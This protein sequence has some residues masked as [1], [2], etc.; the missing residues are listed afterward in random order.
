MDRLAPAQGRCRPD[1]APPPQAWI[2][3]RRV[4]FVGRMDRRR[5]NDAGVEVD[6]VL[7]L[8]AQTRR[9]VLLLAIFASGSVGL[10]QSSFESFLPLRFRSSRTRSSIDGVATPLSWAMRVSI[11]P[12][13]SR[14]SHAAR[15]FAARRW[16]PWSSPLALHQSAL[17]DQPQNPAEDFLMDLVRQATSR[18]RQPGM[19]GNLVTARKAQKLTKRQGIRTAPRDAPLAVDKLVQLAPYAVKEIDWLDRHIKV[20]VTR[21]QVKSAPAW[22][23]LATAN[24]VSE[25][26]LH[27]HFGWPGY[28]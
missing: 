5:N 27:R 1:C 6:R 21:D 26:Q 18:L 3:R 11:S 28:G 25:Q 22:D 8:V 19:I 16:P 14:R 17:G 9:A 4:A 24:E 7:G 12:D 13:T 15:W 20:N 10:V 2:E 23:P